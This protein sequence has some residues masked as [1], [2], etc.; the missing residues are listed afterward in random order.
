MQK[1]DFCSQEIPKNRIISVKKTGGRVKYCSDKCNKKSWT[2]KN[3]IIKN[4]FDNGDRNEWLKTQ[5]GKGWSWENWIAKK[6]NGVWQGFNK[7]YDVL[8]GDKKIDVKTCELYKRPNKRGKCIKN[9]DFQ[10]GW[11]VFNKNTHN[12][13]DEMFCI[14]LINGVP[15][16]IWKI[17]FSIFGKSITISPNSKRLDKYLD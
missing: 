16:K 7:P 11:W 8:I 15:F 3:K 4:S 2:K 6:F 9:R 14:G 10:T 17:P 12:I 1:C 13:A 5:T